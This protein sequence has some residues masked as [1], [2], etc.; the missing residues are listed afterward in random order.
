MKNLMNRLFGKKAENTVNILAENSYRRLELFPEWESAECGY[1][2]ENYLPVPSGEYTKVTL[3]HTFGGMDGHYILRCTV[4]LPTPAEGA[5]LVL[6]VRTGREGQ[7]DALNPQFILY[8]DGKISQ[9][10]DVNHTESLLSGGK[11]TEIL[12]YGYNGTNGGTYELSADFYELDKLCE[13]VMYDIKVAYESFEVLPENSLEKATLY[14]NLEVA[15]NALNLSSPGSDAFRKS[16]LE[17]S[18]YMDK[19]VYN[20]TS[21]KV[22]IYATGH[23]HI[24]V[25]WQWTLAQTEE[26]TQRSFATALKLMEQY[27]DYVFTMSQPQ[28]YKYLKQ[29]APDVYEKVKKAVAEGRWQPEGAMWLEADCNVTGGESFIRQIQHGKDFYR[30]EFG[31][32]TRVLW[33]PDVFGYSAAL[34]QILNKCGVDTFVTSKISWNESNKLPYDNFMWQGIDGSEIYTCFFTA[35]G[36]HDDYEHNWGTTYVARITPSYLVGTWERYQ[37]KE[38]SDKA[39]ITYG[40]GDGG[41]GPTKDHLEYAKRLCAGVDGLPSLRLTNATDYLDDRKKD[42][43]ENSALL[44][45]TP[46]W[47]GELYL[48]MHRGTYTSIAK[49]KKNMRKSEQLL[50]K[51]EGLSSLAL[52][53]FGKEYPAKKLYDTWETVLLNQFHDILPGSSILEV[54][55]DSDTQFRKVFE[56][57]HAIE[58][59]MLHTLSENTCGEGKA[60]VYNPSPFAASGVYTLGEKKYYTE[61]VPAHGYK[62]CSLTEPENTVKIEGRTVENRFFKAI[63]DENG[64]IASL[65]D[66]RNRRELAKNGEALNRLE[67]SEDYPKSYDAWE[68]S[69]YYKQKTAPIDS[70]LS[71]ESFRDE[72]SGGFIAERK[73]Q[74]SLIRQKFVFYSD[75]D[76]IDVE[77]EIDWHEDHKLLKASFPLDI[78]ADSAKYEIQFGHVT[79]PTHENTSWD[80]ARF[81]VCAHK[82]ADISDSGFGFSLLN[83]CKY[84]CS[85][86]GS[87]L[88][89]TLLKCATYPNPEADR[90]FHTF[91]YSLY[92][93]AGP[94]SGSTVKAAYLL[95]EPLTAVLPCGKGNALGEE[96]S[97]VSSSNEQF[98]LETV[99]KAEKNESIV[100]RGYESL[101]RRGNTRISFGFDVEKL[102]LCDML[103]NVTSE[104]P[105]TDNGAELDFSNF[106]IVTLMAVPKKKA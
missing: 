30:E 92:P 78:V 29:N 99:K 57:G 69:D 27:P 73:Y 39:F 88:K 3:P 101:N 80:A 59:E 44:K 68:I 94:L 105:V 20:G 103:E 18:D 106:E 35:V 33:L 96:Y 70:L 63:F 1:K 32:D 76:R 12:L 100:I 97:F 52:T 28:L 79:R 5:E 15:M 93:H 41:G 24:D 50:R 25:A 49:I 19:N 54:Y 85:A 26:K 84:G 47:V 104:I 89:L 4:N 86:E 82:W 10:L 66:K 37:Q 21:S 51:V 23:T 16:L 45:K 2:K 8:V 13:K 64:S 40:Y 98:V 75:T 95:G 72:V 87:T 43:F 67:I 38:Y 14:R 53:L 48:E 81:E 60:L 65:Y 71:F 61:N 90:H 102:Y 6:R 55:K 58:A 7:W 62:L 22:K 56:D 46:R 31:T 17:V 9:G 11:T 83:D 91:T 77:N 36:K 34:P 74:D 42:F